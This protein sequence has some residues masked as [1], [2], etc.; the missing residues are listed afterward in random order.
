M[1]KMNHLKELKKFKRKRKQYYYG[2][3]VYHNKTIIKTYYNIIISLYQYVYNKITNYIIKTNKVKI[4]KHYKKGLSPLQTS[5]K[6]NIPLRKIM[7][8]LKKTKIYVRPKNHGYIKLSNEILSEIKIMY[9]KLKYSQ[10]KIAKTFNLSNNKVRRILL[11]M[12]IL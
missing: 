8:I 5:N 7:N 3:N 1:N 6:L 11:E 4:K 10:I 12:D 9:V 2:N